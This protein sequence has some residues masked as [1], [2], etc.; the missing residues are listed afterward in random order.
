MGINVQ[1]KISSLSQYRQR[2][3]KKR[4]RELFYAYFME[5]HYGMGHKLSSRKPDLDF[6]EGSTFWDSE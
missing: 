2:K 6:Y 3:I 4:E 1:D 5:G